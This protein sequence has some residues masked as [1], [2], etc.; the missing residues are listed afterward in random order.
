MTDLDLAELVADVDPDA[1]IPRAVAPVLR[2]VEALLLA[3]PAI[4][5]IDVNPVR[6]ISDGAVALDAL[7]RVRQAGAMMATEGA[8][9]GLK[10]IDFGQ[11]IAGPLL[12][13]LLA[14][15]G[16]EVIHVD[17][18]GGPRWDDPANAVLQRGKRS[19]ELDLKTAAG[20]ETALDLVRHA[21]MLV[22]NFRPGVMDRLGLGYDAMQAAN[23]RLVYCSIP[24][25]SG[26]DARASMRGWEGIVSAATSI[27]RPP[28]R[29]GPAGPIIDTDP[30]FAATPLLSTYAA[31]IAAHA[32]VAALLARDRSGRGQRVEVSL[33]DA[34]YEVFGHELQM[35]H[36]MASGA[37][38]PPPR[39]GLGHYKCKD[40]RWLHL[41]LFEDRH[42][43]WFA[44]EFVPEWLAEGV[45]EPDR[46][47]A[48]PELQVELIKRFT[49]LFRT[50]DAA[51]WEHDI[52]ER[53][54]A[55]CAVCQTTDEWLRTDEG[56]RDS[57]AVADVVDPVLGS[58]AQL[59]EPVV[60]SRTALSP[61]PRVIGGAATFQS[62]ST[63]HSLNGEAAAPLEGVRVVDFTH[64]LAGPTAGRVLAEYG[65]DVIK[66]NKTED[67]AI[68]WHMWIN[69]GKRSM[70]LDL[71]AAQG[72]EI[73]S[74]L[75]ADTDVVSQNFA[76]G[77][78]DRLGI[79][80]ADARAA[81]PGVV[82][83]SIS[84]FGYLGKR[85]MW[86]GR[87]ELG[88]A[89]AGLQDRWHN[90]E[91]EPTMMSFPVSDVGSGHL[92]AFGI[93]LSLYHRN[94]TGEGQSV[95]ASLAHTAS[96][97]QAPFMLAYDGKVWDLPHGFDARGWNAR[98]RLYKAS[99][100]RWFFAVVDS[101]DG[102]E[103]LDGV[104]DEGREAR[105]ETEPAQVW[106]DRIN[107]AGGAAHLSVT[108]EEAAAD[109]VARARGIVVEVEAGRLTVGPGPR[110]SETH[111]RFG[112]PGTVPGID[113]EQIVE[114][115]G[116]SDRW[117]ALVAEGVVAAP[118]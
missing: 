78:A 85:G 112:P 73:I 52:N 64:V 35:A 79:G 92:A 116:M 105:F 88:Q 84:A 33:F 42:M 68:P 118:T 46:L 34:A 69:A 103:G 61:S 41:C 59:G 95:S 2:A 12:A 1:S 113:G 74:R 110:L 76:L 30:S 39:P 56:G 31:A 97:I 9:D 115:L 44:Q 40:G 99:D 5:E 27:Y 49:E 111:V 25:F 45:A 90:E 114:E 98:N 94:R 109:P 93:L 81:V 57:H 107:R 43:R 4:I 53:T 100:D 55:P 15:A 14:D 77:V 37:F 24:G 23:P 89:V 48:D 18:P 21:D 67:L 63:N 16:A 19:I 96:F 38:K 104:T 11:Y 80:E 75:L 83:S 8:L 102:I 47:R 13:M 86:R 7:D 71:K 32:V 29:F 82:Y 62:S 10:V 20:V 91:G 60:L 36:N 22:E 65:A 72:R 117:E 58:T 70:L 66:V 26:D 108:G 54:G 87:E 50:R 101:F 28:R 51:E 3:H 106:I 6:L 17:P